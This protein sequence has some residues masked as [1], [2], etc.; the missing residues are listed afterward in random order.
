MWSESFS[1]HTDSKP[2]GPQ[3]VGMDVS[4]SAKHVYGI[5]EHA[6]SFAL[7]NTNG[8]GM[9]AY[10]EPYRL[11]NLDVFEYELDVPMALYG[12]V[13]FMLAH[14]ATKTSAMLWL[15]AAETYID[16]KDTDYGKQTH[17]I[18]ESGVLDVFL[19]TSSDPKEVF[20]AYAAL[21]GFLALPQHFAIGYHQVLTHPSPAHHY[22]SFLPQCRWNYKSEQDVAEVDAGFD[23]HDI[24]YDVIWLDIEHTDGKQYFTWDK[25]LFP[26]PVEMQ[27]KIAA[28][29]RK[30]VTIIDPHIKRDSGYHVHSNALSN[31]YYV[32]N[33]VRIR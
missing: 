5:P 31:G 29:G 19:V 3:A 12:A 24:P 18:S 30:M 7:K 1:S 10:S 16:I 11:Y 26:N 22:P 6:S 27:N 15:N 4:F 32:T 9:G 17:W 21:T 8:E 33:K 14:D 2:K 13:P 20:F 28:K 25:F 23:E